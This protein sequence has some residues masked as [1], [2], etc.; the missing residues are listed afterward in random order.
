MSRIDWHQCKFIE[1][2]G[3]LK[4]LIKKRFGREPSVTR[5][6]EIG[7]CLQQGRLFYEAASEAPLEI[8]PLQQFYGMLAFARALIIASQRRSLATL[9]QSHG[10]R[11][12]SQHGM[13]IAEMKVKIQRSG[14][15]QEFNDVVASLNR[16]CYIDNETKWRVIPIPSA[17]SSQLVDLELS[18]RDLLGR[19]PGLDAL[20]RMTFRSEPLTEPIHFETGYRDNRGFRIR[21]DDREIFQNRESIR[22]IVDRWRARFP[23]LRAWRLNAVQQAWGYSIVHFRN[24]SPDG[25]LEFSEDYLDLDGSNGRERPVA[26]DNNVQFPLGEKL[27][28]LAGGFSNSYTY[29]ISPVGGNFLSEFSVQYLTLFLL[30]SLVRYRPQSWTHAISRSSMINQPADDETFPGQAVDAAK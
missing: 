17:V 27:D 12:V 11:D 23:F 24:A 28:P 4:S 9:S 18:L 26:G 30:S 1:S 22:G 19:I 13:R 8:R 10:L 3:N 21:M 5:L 20:Y 25:L 16:L 2:G 29:A 15:F 6:R 7:A 14:T